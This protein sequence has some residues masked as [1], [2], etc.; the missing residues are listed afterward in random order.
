MSM[1]YET[2][3]ISRGFTLSTV[4]TDKFKTEALNVHF[5]V[6]LSSVPFAEV[7]LPNVMS[8]GCVKYPTQRLIRK[9]LD[10]LFSSSASVYLPTF[11][12]HMSV[13]FSAL[14]LK[15]AYAYDG[16]D[17]A[18]GTSELLWDIMLD[19]LVTNGAFSEEYT[20]REK[21]N[22]CD[23]LR[24]VINN[25]DTYAANRCLQL[26][27]EQEDISFLYST[28]TAPYEALTPSSLYESYL[29]LLSDSPVIITYVGEN[30]GF[31]QELA[32]DLAHR[33][34][35]TQRSS[36][37]NTIKLKIP[38][39]TRYFE[40]KHNVKQARLVIGFRDEA[41]KGDA[42]YAK[43]VF[44]ELYGQSPVSKLFCNVREKQSLCYYCTSGR[45]HE[46]G[47]MTVKTGI[48]AENKD[49]AYEEILHQLELMK[50]GDFTNG[51]LENAKKGFAN[52][53][54][55]IGDSPDSI[56]S[57][58]F[59]GILRGNVLSPKEEA[60]KIMAVTKEQVCRAACGIIPDTVY[61]MYGDETEDGYEG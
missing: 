54:L 35:S 20:E 55:S 31:A 14:Y 22:K 17:I 2:K 26:M 46:T 42:L 18:K 51:E 53:V 13:N 60:D 12:D 15:N 36:Y 50:S 28:N 25:K 4:K 34:Y 7:L 52:Q 24:A 32:Q 16:C 45:N 61:F 23:A 48:K 40:E 9:R 58:L 19:P 6:P 29:R 59:K 3:E 56:A 10:R 44:D 38:E 33:L 47:I 1:I 43:T 39:K 27:C 8:K 5:L 11:G 37:E 41:S 49:K 30:T 57:S 21:K